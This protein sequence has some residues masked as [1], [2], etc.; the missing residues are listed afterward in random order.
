VSFFARLVT[1]DFFDNFFWMSG[2]K[3]PS[4]VNGS[5]C[6]CNNV[7]SLLSSENDGGFCT[8]FIFSFQVPSSP[9]L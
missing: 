1:F 6:P 2:E 3:G 9:A 5:S 8:L 7:G 4:Q